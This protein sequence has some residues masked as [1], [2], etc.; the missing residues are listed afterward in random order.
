MSDRPD[1][2]PVTFR[3]KISHVV[4]ECGEVLQAIGK[5]DRFGERATDH[6]TGIQYDNV[7]ALKNELRD[8]IEACER[9]EKLL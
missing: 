2:L 4:E 5:L 6:K 8:L 3:D 1:L 9:V 7:A